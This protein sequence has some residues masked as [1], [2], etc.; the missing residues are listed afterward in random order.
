MCLKNFTAL[1]RS[2]VSFS[3]ICGRRM[4]TSRN[5][6]H[7]FMS[8]VVLFGLAHIDNVSDVVHSPDPL[9]FAEDIVV[10]AVECFPPPGFLMHADM[11][12]F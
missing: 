2:S 6:R 3:K 10:H 12:L 7:P 1:T 8:E 9:N 4:G 5:D 11:P